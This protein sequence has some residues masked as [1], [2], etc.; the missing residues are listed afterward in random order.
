MMCRR[1]GI[2]R[3]TK[4]QIPVIDENGIQP[5]FIM[6]QCER[7]RCDEYRIFANWRYPWES[8]HRVIK[9]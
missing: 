7:E 4:I 5:F 6:Q 1:L 3:Y 8:R 2:H 9:R